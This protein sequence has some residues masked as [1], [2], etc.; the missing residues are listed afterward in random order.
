[1]STPWNCRSKW[2]SHRRMSQE[3]K[4]EQNWNHHDSCQRFLMSL[5]CTSSVKITS[6]LYFS[7]FTGHVMSTCIGFNGAKHIQPIGERCFFFLCYL[8]LLY[9]SGNTCFVC[10]TSINPSYCLKAA[11][12]TGLWTEQTETSPGVLQ[13]LLHNNATATFHF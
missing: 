4:A 11:A 10:F 3:K 5:V 7:P 2:L 13:H 12:F 6:F 9:P 8:A 1:M